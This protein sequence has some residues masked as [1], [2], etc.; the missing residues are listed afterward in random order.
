MIAS[1]LGYKAR[2]CNR[3]CQQ[4]F[5]ADRE[6][7]LNYGLHRIN[8]VT[9]LHREEWSLVACRCAYCS[10]EVKGKIPRHLQAKFAIN[11]R[12]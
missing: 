12:G 6:S 9:C 8:N 3:N 1:V 4:G 5:K 7:G 11:N 10:T 2:F